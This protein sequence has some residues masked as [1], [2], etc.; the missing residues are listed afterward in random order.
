MDLDSFLRALALFALAS[1]VSACPADRGGDGGGT[2]R[3]CGTVTIGGACTTQDDC[4]CNLACADAE[5]IQVFDPPAEPTPLPP[6]PAIQSLCSQFS[7]LPCLQTSSDCPQE[8]ATARAQATAEGC[9]VE[10]DATVQCFLQNPPTCVDETPQFSEQC[11]AALAAQDAC[12][13]SP[14][15]QCGS[16]TPTPVMDAGTS[17]T[18]PT[19]RAGYSKQCGTEDRKGA[20]M[21]CR[22][23][24]TSTGMIWACR[25]ESGARSGTSFGIRSPEDDCCSFAAVVED[26]CGLVVE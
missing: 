15:R 7:Q 12:G 2:S 4:L 9:E 22:R 14:I 21:A 16:T 18:A 13:C 17:T 26:R 5:C 1:V 6:T 20:S 25:C 11:T 8:G 10:F 24:P 23:V 3:T 19:C